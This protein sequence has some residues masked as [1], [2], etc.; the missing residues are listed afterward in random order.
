[1][2]V[3]RIKKVTSREYMMKFLYNLDVV[4]EELT[5]L[6]GKIEVFL[7][8]NSEYII[9]RFEE[10][11]LQNSDDVEVEEGEETALDDCID[12]KYMAKVCSAYEENHEEIDSV[13]NKYANNWSIET[14]PK[15]DLAILRL[16]IAEITY[17]EIPDK[18]SINEA[19]EMAKMYCDDKSPKFING[20]LGSYLNERK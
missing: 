16:A 12:R 11:K 17:T 10:L 14:M 18:A 2:K 8:G 5:G 15:V 13:I 1:M 20:V 4:K 9:N 6:C 19:I 7:E 3:Y